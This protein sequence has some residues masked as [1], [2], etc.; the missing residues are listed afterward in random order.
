MGASGPDTSL[1][2]VHYS[3]AEP[4]HRVQAA[5][6][7]IHPEVT[8]EMQERRFWE[9]QGQLQRKDFMLYD[10]SNWP[11]IEFGS[12]RTAAMGAQ[13]GLYPRNPLQQIPGAPNQFYPQGQG[14]A[15]GPPAKRPRQAPPS[16]LPAMPTAAAGMPHDTSIEDEENTTLG[17]LL[18]HLT[19][20]D[21]SS[22]RYI[23]H[24]E[25]MEEV[26]SSP[27]ATGHIMPVELGFGL[28]GELAKL[29]EGIF[30][31]PNYKDASKTGALKP[32]RKLDPGKF[33][34]FEQKVAA[35]ISDGQKE[36]ESMKSEHA[37]KMAQMKQESR[38]WSQA[39]RKLR[40]TMFDDSHGSRH[41]GVSRSRADLEGV[42]QELENSLGIKIGPQQEVVCVQKGGL[43]EEEAQQPNGEHVNNGA[44]GPY[45][46]NGALNGV[47]EDSV[48]GAD[49]TAASLL[50]QYGTS[51][52]AT[53]P[54]ANISTPQLSHPTSQAQSAGATLS[55]VP[56]DQPQHAPYPDQTGL[57]DT[58]DN[59][60]NDDLL[61]EDID[62]DIDMS[63]LPDTT[64]GE[65][66]VGESDWVMVDQTG[67]DQVQAQNTAAVGDSGATA[68]LA[69]IV[70]QD[71]TT[72]L[73]TATAAD[74]NGLPAASTTE[75]P[76]PHTEDPGSMFDSTDFSTLR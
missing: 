27:Y 24:H 49:N 41:D 25:W 61:M 2:I 69:T 46:G 73:A 72:A 42:V 1:W 71:S 6:V 31:A 5:R 10:R 26:F 37:K 74:D 34:E 57:Q 65:K 47:G 54:A 30:D 28:S 13:A 8:R 35:Y 75:T 76:G 44:S 45:P 53:T 70:A 33:A 64:A 67:E 38:A 36:L 23:Q 52:F 12:S 32:Y 15:I 58:T 14:A 17:D 48:M 50:D 68:P 3:Q 22:M 62:L 56:A 39:E 43:I 63:G 55:A 60:V 51:S 19:P 9:G 18:D 29:T 40:N 4:Q 21:I 7:P 59:Q 66:P 11:N 20:R 16:Q